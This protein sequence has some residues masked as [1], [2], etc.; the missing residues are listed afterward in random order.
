MFG[1]KVVAKSVCGTSI[2][3]PLPVIWSQGLVEMEFALP[4]D[5]TEASGMSL[6]RR[7]WV[8]RFDVEEEGRALAEKYVPVGEGIFFNL[9]S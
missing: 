7:L 3:L 6:L 4:T 8:S 2:S 1:V 5:S 9:H